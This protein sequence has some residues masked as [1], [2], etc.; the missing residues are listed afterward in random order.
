MYDDDDHSSENFP[1]NTQWRVGKVV[2]YTLEP[3]Y[4]DFVGLFLKVHLVIQA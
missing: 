4:L 3:F 2:Q 1:G